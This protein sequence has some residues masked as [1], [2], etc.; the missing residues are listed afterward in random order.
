MK[1]AECMFCYQ[2]EAKLVAVF[3]WPDAKGLSVEWAAVGACDTAFLCR[4][5]A[6]QVAILLSEAILLVE[7]GG[8][9]MERVYAALCEID[10]CREMLE[11]TT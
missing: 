9:P 11:A 8:F 1:A 10:E 7:K 5:K 6:M 2:P 4:S 3:P